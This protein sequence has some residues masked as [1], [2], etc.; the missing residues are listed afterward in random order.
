MYILI[1]LGRD[2][3]VFCKHLLLHYMLSYG[4]KLLDC[5]CKGLNMTPYNCY[6]SCPITYASH[7]ELT[8]DRTCL[9]LTSPRRQMTVLLYVVSGGCVL[10]EMKTYV[11]IACKIDIYYNCTGLNVSWVPFFMVFA[12]SC[13]HEIWASSPY[14]VCYI[15]R[16]FI[17]APKSEPP[18]SFWKS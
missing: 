13:F 2:T 12:E 6:S 10:T 15:N 9:L 5:S 11:W 1:C 17:K 7:L 16:K 4:K 3:Q 14:V 8:S 18:A